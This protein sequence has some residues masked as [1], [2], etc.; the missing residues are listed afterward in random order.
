MMALELDP[1]HVGAHE[2]LGELY[3]MKDDLE[4]A[5]NMLVKLEKLV[6]KNAQEYKDLLKAI[7]SYQL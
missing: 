3:L 2:Y 4:K 1:E 5:F 6:G 7:E